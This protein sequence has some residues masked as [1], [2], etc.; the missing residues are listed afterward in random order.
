MRSLSKGLPRQPKKNNHFSALPYPEAPALMAML[1]E[2]DTVGR[3]ALRFL[4]LTAARSG[5]VRHASWKEIDF[6]AGL[7]TV[8]ASR[9]KAGEEHTV[10][11]TE[12]VVEILEALKAVHGCEADAPLFP[13][14][15]GKPLSDM[16]LTKVLRTALSGSHTVHGFRSTFRDWAAEQTSFPGEVVEAALAH[17]IANKV[18]AAY[19]RT[20]YLDKRR[21][22]MSEWAA[23]LSST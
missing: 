21:T 17:A 6:N 1:A 3:R 5:E 23:Y 16:T 8:P 2:Q 10:P 22:L 15:G 14:K 9:M 19:R 12:P 4:I 11:L 13:G 20:N 18:E 7:W